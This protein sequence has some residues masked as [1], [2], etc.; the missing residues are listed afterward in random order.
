MLSAVRELH[1]SC[2]CCR[3]QR[4]LLVDSAQYDMAVKLLCYLWRCICRKSCVTVA[5]CVVHQVTCW[6]GSGDLI[7]QTAVHGRHVIVLAAHRQQSRILIYLPQSLQGVLGLG[8]MSA[9][10]CMSGA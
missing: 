4:L 10:G 9:N 8:A 5:E 6:V 2:S 7:R 1:C 3:L